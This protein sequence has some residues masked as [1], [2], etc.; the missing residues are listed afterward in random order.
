M[1]HTEAQQR[2]IDQAL[3]AQQ[4]I[5]EIMRMMFEVQNGTVQK[6]QAYREQRVANVKDKNT[7]PKTR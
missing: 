1:H 4:W 5:H 6:E 7:L 2:H 3:F